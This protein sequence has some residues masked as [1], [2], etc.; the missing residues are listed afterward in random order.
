LQDQTIHSRGDLEF[1]RKAFPK[2]KIPESRINSSHKSK[3]KSEDAQA[4]EKKSDSAD[5]KMKRSKRVS[6]P[7]EGTKSLFNFFQRQPKSLDEAESATIEPHVEGEI[8]LS[9]ASEKEED[10]LAQSTEEDEIAEFSVRKKSK[11]SKKRIIDDD[12]D[13]EEDNKV[14]LDLGESEEE[15]ENEEE[16]ARHNHDD[17]ER[18]EIEE[19]D[20]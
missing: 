15:N 4:D 19:F 10:I 18:E 7:P 16:E 2:H 11:L 6:G 13:S 1:L 8:D 14:D 3:R 5:K 12:A 17:E 9:M 20:N